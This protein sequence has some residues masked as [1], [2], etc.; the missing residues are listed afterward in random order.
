MIKAPYQA[1]VR[2]ANSV[3]AP[4]LAPA[5][6]L[7]ADIAGILVRLVIR[8]RRLEDV[9]ALSMV[10][11]QFHQASEP[12]L[13]LLNNRCD[14]ADKEETAAWRATFDATNDRDIQLL[15]VRAA[16]RDAAQL[17]DPDQRIANIIASAFR[18]IQ[19]ARGKIDDSL[20]IE[21]PLLIVEA[22]WD[23][24]SDAV[25]FI[26]RAV[27]SSRDYC[28]AVP[29]MFALETLV[30]EAGIERAKSNQKVDEI[31]VLRALVA[32]KSVTAPENYLQEPLLKRISL[33]FNAMS[34]ENRWALACCMVRHH[35]PPIPR[36]YYDDREPKVWAMVVQ[37]VAAAISNGSLFDP[38]RHP[39]L[40]MLLWQ[41]CHIAATRVEFEIPK[42]MRE[43]MN[44]GLRTRLKAHPY[45]SRSDLK[46]RAADFPKNA[47]WPLVFVAW[48]CHLDKPKEPCPLLREIDEGLASGEFRFISPAQLSKLKAFCKDDPAAGLDQWLA[49]R[50]RSLKTRAL[51]KV[52]KTIL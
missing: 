9:L 35:V 8:S 36:N 7:P 22:L 12:V 10:D 4:V 6:Q 32:F 13:R 15:L 25:E 47:P 45:L 11:R 2:H 43:L 28:E 21:A 19:K 24:P 34:A 40:S 48:L 27:H 5:L 51:H 23:S 26:Q 20:A 44:D 37:Q 31:D 49:L 33:A 29:T 18:F 30:D 14:C 52:K 38:S 39:D 16:A 41:T 3:H 17:L 42:P 50:L 46:S 1:T